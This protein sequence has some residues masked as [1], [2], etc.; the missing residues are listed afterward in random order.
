MNCPK[1]YGPL[2]II[3]LLIRAPY[4]SQDL[5]QNDPVHN[6]VSRSSYIHFNIIPTYVYIFIAV[7]FFLGFPNK[8]LC[9]FI[10]S[11]MRRGSLPW[12]PPTGYQIATEVTVTQIG[13]Q[14]T[15]RL[16]EFPW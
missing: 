12:D 8:T 3:A 11:L 13:I 1:L 15:A 2:R 9:G 10:V 16:T 5:S 6:S 14:A 7:S 4:W